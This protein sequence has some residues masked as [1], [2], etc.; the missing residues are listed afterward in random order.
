[1][2]SDTFSNIV[3]RATAAATTAAAEAA[4]STAALE[5]VHDY[6]RDKTPSTALAIVFAALFGASAIA[7]TYQ[8]Y[9][10]RAWYFSA[11]LVGAFMMSVGYI[12]RV[13]S[14]HNYTNLTPYI[15]QTLFVLL[16]P[17][18]YAATIYM[19]YGRI[20]LL[21][22]AADLSLI[23]PNW[24]TKV[25]VLSDCFAFVIQAGGGALL[26]SDSKAKVGKNILLVGLYVQLASFAFF[27]VISSVFYFRVAKAGVD[28]QKYGRYHWTT[29][30]KVLYFAAVFIIMRC[31]F[32]IIEYSADKTSSIQQKE[33]W[34]YC[35]D[36]VPMLMVQ[37]VFNIVHGGMVLP[38]A[39]V[40]NKERESIAGESQYE[41]SNTQSPV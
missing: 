17:S 13:I 26:T 35:L 22:N 8:L 21:V 16:P 38:K 33:V 12:F 32:R 31:V 30:L 28:M 36:A 9:R 1:M 40:R 20:V 2:Y 14:I 15:I 7:H 5:E 3:E 27:L 25:F 34:A 18:L 10:Y 37:C 4:S 41:L 24:V 29:M 19:I 6:W 39:G 23:R 11:F